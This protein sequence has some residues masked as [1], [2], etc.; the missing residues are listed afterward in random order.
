MNALK[1][2]AVCTNNDFKD[3]IQSISLK[4]AFFKLVAF[5]FIFSINDVSFPQSPTGGGNPVS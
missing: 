3:P 2:N 4:G 1:N 5:G